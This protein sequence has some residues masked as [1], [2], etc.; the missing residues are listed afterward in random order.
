MLS[1]YDVAQYFCL[2]HLQAG[3]TQGLH[4][5]ALQKLLYYAQ[6]YYLAQFGEPLFDEPIE[7]WQHGPVVVDVWRR[8]KGQRN[9][10]PSVDFDA[11]DDWP[12]SCTAFLDQVFTE[13]GQ[14]NS[15]KLE[16]MS[17][18]ERPWLDHYLNKGLIPAEEL[19]S[20][21]EDYVS[22]DPTSPTGYRFIVP[23]VKQIELNGRKRTLRIYEGELGGF[24][25]DLPEFPGCMSQGKTQTEAHQNVLLA[26]KDWANGEAV[27]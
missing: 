15:F 23:Q 6:G 17:H 16:H 27:S 4:S 8:Y 18:A 20:Y 24:V 11:F 19:A 10:M 1:A 5:I 14:F 21:F 22:E 3:D 7:A 25:A 12:D 13:Y 2:K 9:I 26:Y